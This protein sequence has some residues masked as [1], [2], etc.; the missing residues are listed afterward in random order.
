MAIVCGVMFSAFTIET[1]VGLRGNLARV[2]DTEID[3]IKNLH[4]IKHWVEPELIPFGWGHNDSADSNFAAG[5]T[6]AHAAGMIND[7]HE[8]VVDRATLKDD[9]V[10]AGNPHA[11][12][13]IMQEDMMNNEDHDSI[14][15]DI[16]DESLRYSGV[17]R[18]SLS[19]S[20]SSPLN[21]R[22]G[23]FEDHGEKIANLFKM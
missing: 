5:G 20:K 23:S 2:Q 10:Y 6:D 21:Q 4:L 9:D 16:F 15:K 12:L 1:C 14:P 7:S 17:D 13:E 11:I 19:I 8:V 22:R 3:T 18:P